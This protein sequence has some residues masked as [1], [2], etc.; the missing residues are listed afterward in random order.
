[1]NI[2]RSTICSREYKERVLYLQDSLFLNSAYQKHYPPAL[3]DEVWRLEKIA[4]DGTSHRKLNELGVLTVRDFLRLCAR[5]QSNL[6]AVS[7]VS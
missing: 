7:D 5:D 2:Y 4:K 1:M 6:R 3:G